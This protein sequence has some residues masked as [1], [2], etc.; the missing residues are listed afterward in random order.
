MHASKYLVA[1]L[2]SLVFASAAMAQASQLVAGPMVGATA[3]RQ[4]KVWMQASGPGTASIEYWE[5]T[6]SA[7]VR[8]SEPILLRAA[9]D[10]IGQFGLGMLEP[11][12]TYGYRVL[13]DGREQKVPQ[14]LI[15][16]AQALWQWRTDAPDWKLAFGSCVFANEPRYDRPGRPYGGPPE[17]KR[18]FDA[19]ARQQPDLTLWGGDYLYF[20]EVDEDSELGLRYR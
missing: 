6:E 1:T 17:A 5:T 10:F 3:M 18:I 8:K 13:I 9:E 20:R 19:M 14:S 11:G 7:K 2:L 15:F 4:A 12:K 16:K